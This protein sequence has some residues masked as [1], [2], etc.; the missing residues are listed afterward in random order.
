MHLTFDGALSLAPRLR[1]WADHAKAA[2]RGSV[3]DWYDDYIARCSSL[4][5]VCAALARDHQL[6][7]EQVHHTVVRGLVGLY[8]TE[9]G[10]EQRRRRKGGF[11]AGN[12]HGVGDGTERRRPK[13]EGDM[14][15]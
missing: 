7:G 14:G 4:R 2:A 9:R 12:P 13:A 15:A 5:G 1:Q 6:D 10:R 8:W 11:E 3:H